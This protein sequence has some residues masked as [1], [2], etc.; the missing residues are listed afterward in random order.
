[1]RRVAESG[2]IDS[3]A[4][5]C[6]T[7][8]HGDCGVVVGTWCETFNQERSGKRRA[9]VSIFSC[10]ISVLTVIVRHFKL[11]LLI[12]LN[13]R[14][15]EAFPAIK[16]AIQRVEREKKRVK[17]KNDDKKSSKS[18]S[19][20]G[21]VSKVKS[22]VPVSTG[23]SSKSFTLQRRLSTAT[24]VKYDMYLMNLGTMLNLFGF[25][26]GQKEEFSSLS[27]RS[28]QARKAHKV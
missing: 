16:G 18:S 17:H 14:Y 4:L 5:R 1:M 12:L 23:T 26:L 21:L 24:T 19:K 3:S 2:G 27:S 8:R 7:R 28:S 10:D 9:L 20:S 25:V 11:N 13:F 6:K 15:C 22:D